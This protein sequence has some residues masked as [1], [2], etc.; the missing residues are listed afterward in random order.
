MQVNRT[1][2]QN[3]DKLVAA[4]IPLAGST[5]TVANSGAVLQLGDTF[6]LFDGTIT[7]PVPTINL[8][9]AGF[10]A[11]NYTWDTSQLLSAGI[12][13]VVTNSLPLLP[14]QI[15]DIDNQPTNVELTWNSFPSLL[16]TI[17]YSYNLLTW[18]VAQAN[19]PANTVIN[20]TTYVLNTGIPVTSS[21]YTLVQYQMGT[22]NAQIQDVGKT[23][24]AGAFTPGIGVATYFPN[25]LVTPAY[26]GAPTLQISGTGTDLAT[27]F[28]NQA[29]ITF[30]LTVGTNVTDL[31]LTS[32]A[33]NGARGGGATPR[34]YGLYVTTPT[35]TDEL[36]GPSYAFVTARPTWDP[37]NINLTGFASLQNLTAGQV[38][39][40]KLVVFM[41]V[42]GNSIEL[43]D[44]TVRGNV[45]PGVPPAYSGV[46]QL[47]LRI[48]QQ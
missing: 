15:T 28:A 26:A 29:W 5:I 34:G 19:I 18:N 12:I 44:I 45:S 7:G 6:D 22:T 1:N 23:M 9:G 4:N 40:F 47:F 20:A 48:R 39:T 43:D 36:V 35:T 8:T 42:T 2:V 25:A 46:N 16:Y 3:A 17:Q 41:P 13:T 27:A 33:F 32:L 21:N 30:E 24:A 31:D 11:V 14:L 38:I 10:A 37:Q